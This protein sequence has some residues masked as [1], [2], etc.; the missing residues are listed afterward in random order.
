MALYRLLWLSGHLTGVRCLARGRFVARVARVALA[1][2]VALGTLTRIAW[3]KWLGPAVARPFR[4]VRDFAARRLVRDFAARRLVG[5][6]G[7]RA[8]AHWPSIAIQQGL[9]VAVPSDLHP[10]VGGRTTRAT[11]ATGATGAVRTAVFVGGATGTEIIARIHGDNSNG[12]P[13]VGLR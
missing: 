10:A 2:L 1:P 4:L 6:W 12:L 7:N 8:P 13:G 11:R 3:R 5:A 9:A